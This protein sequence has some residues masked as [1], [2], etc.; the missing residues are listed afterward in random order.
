MTQ[1]KIKRLY[2]KP[3]LIR[4]QVGLNNKFSNTPG[5]R[6]MPEIDGVSVSEMAAKY[7]SPLY[8]LSEGTIR[9]KV[10][11][12][13]RAFGARYP[14]VRLGWSYKTNY[15]SA[16]CKVM[17]QEGSWAEV[18]SGQE[19]RM[20]C[21]LG[22]DPSR[23]I[24]N[25]P[26]KDDASLEASVRGGSRVHLDN[27]EEIQRL[28]EIVRRVGKPGEKF[29]VAIRINMQLDAQHWDRFG[30]NL[31]SGRA[32][33]V[34]RHLAD[35]D[36]L[37]LAGFHTHIG[38]YVDNVEMYR[39]A[40]RRMVELAVWAREHAGIRLKW[41]DMGGGFATKNTLHWA[42]Q[43]GEVTCPG[44]QQYADA[45]CPVLAELPLE[46]GEELPEL[47][48]ETGRA[49]VD[50]A[51]HLVVK[52]LAERRLADGT[53]AVVLNAGVNLLSSTAWYRYDVLPV[54]TGETMIT[55][56]TTLLGNL[57]M[58]IDVLRKGAPLP[59]VHPGDLLVVKDIG[60]YNFTQSTQFIHGRPPI[61]MIDGEAQVHV[62]REQEQAE[63]WQR[64]DRIPEHLKELKI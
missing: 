11:D 36:V 25:G 15:L 20:A 55:E 58:Q 45:I 37:E 42:Y 13:H 29:P 14:K 44:F 19:Y 30:F 1:T 62:V 8:V 38:T 39:R 53:R 52:V 59:S 54:N 2:E 5:R 57:C 18:V 33:E 26:H 63:D 32:H 21:N 22:V 34:I 60:A 64:L 51:M 50:D 56:D 35:S 16:V 49:L 27:N 17:H 31:D 24:F 7:G 46:D 40:A 61:V 9:R 12:F 23:I 6:S 43:S 10:R 47:F 4:H 41:W 48:F 28:E 3:T